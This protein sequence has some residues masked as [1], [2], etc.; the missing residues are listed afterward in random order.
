MDPLKMYFLF[1]MGIFNCYVNLPEGI[2]VFP[3][4]VGKPP[5]WMVGEN[6]G[7]PLWANGWFGGKTHYFWETSIESLMN[8]H[9]FILLYNAMY[10]KACFTSICFI[11]TRS[12]QK[13]ARGRKEKGGDGF[14]E[15][16]IRGMKKK[17]WKVMVNTSP[18]KVTWKIIVSAFFAY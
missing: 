7:K 16:L 5:K 18:W 8:W 2:W 11:S 6:N 14:P 17:R 3:K 15:R 9:W 12:A 13:T 10:T 4:I 1:K